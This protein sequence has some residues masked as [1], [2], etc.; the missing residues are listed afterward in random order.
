M[1]TDKSLTYHES[2]GYEILALTSPL[3][4]QGRFLQKG[5]QREIVAAIVWNIRRI[6]RHRI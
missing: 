6:H 2:V 1:I 3:K 4:K 5:S